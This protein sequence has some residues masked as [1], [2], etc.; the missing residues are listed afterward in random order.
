[1]TEIGSIHTFD[2]SGFL[3]WI[4]GCALAVLLAGAAL[5]IVAVSALHLVPFG[6]AGA[7]G[8]MPIWIR[9]GISLASLA[10]TLILHELTH[11]LLF[12][13][14]A[15]AGARVTF[16]ANWRVGM[17]FACAQG[18]I[19]TRRHYQMIAV[20]PS[21]AVSGLAL[22][23]GAATGDL[24]VGLGVGILHLSCCTGDWGYLRAIR[25]NAAITHCEDMLW[26]VRFYGDGPGAFDDRGACPRHD[27]SGGS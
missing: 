3:R 11:A 1:M 24:L 14:L 23:L 15:P 2:D 5:L 16:G 13:L 21:V 7:L 9:I 12:K 17:I 18:V 26:G 27:S 6:P 10:G 4:T 22:A 25:R 19:Y 8:S 20:A